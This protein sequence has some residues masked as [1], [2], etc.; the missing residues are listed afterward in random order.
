MSGKTSE[1]FPPMSRSPLNE[2]AQL[3]LDQGNEYSN[4]PIGHVGIGIGK[5]QAFFKP[6]EFYDSTFKCE[7]NF[8][9]STC[10]SM[11]GV[12]NFFQ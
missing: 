1:N 10:H 9:P 8:K 2:G 6:T 7:E 3:G 11:L 4:I 12:N 5:L